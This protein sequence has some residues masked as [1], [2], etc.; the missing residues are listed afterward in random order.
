MKKA[1]CTLA[2]AGALCSS[3]LQAADK[4]VAVK[5]NDL[6]AAARSTIQSRIGK[7]P[8][9]E[10]L[11]TVERG[12]ATYE[13]QITGAAQPR[14]FTVNDDGELVAEQAFLQELPRPAR[15]TIRPQVADGTLG[16]ISK[17]TDDGEV[18]YEVQMTKA[19]R[20]RDFTVAEDGALVEIQV[21]VDEVPGAVRAAIRRQ[22]RGGECGDIYKSTE[23]GEAEY[24]VEIT[25]SGKSRRLT[26]NARGRI[27]Y[28]E[29]PLALAE[30][31]EPVQRTVKDQLDGGRLVSVDRAQEDGTVTYEVELVKAGKRRSLSIKPDG[32]LA[33]QAD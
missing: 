32:Q 18:T 12:E 25:R 14:S 29:T 16:D 27:T 4:A 15:E 11:K 10:I 9:G 31:P 28:E 22:S 21:F 1:F 17:V 5:L 33:P 20:A 19:G 2:L 26:F 6:P 8:V 13:V 7:A 23:D 24:D 3:G 30:T